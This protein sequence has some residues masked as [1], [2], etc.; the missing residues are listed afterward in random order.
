[1]AAAVVRALHHLGVSRVAVGAAYTGQVTDTDAVLLSR[2]G[3][4]T[5]TVIP[6]LEDR[7]GLPVVS[8]SQAG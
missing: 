5:L 3:L 8:S 2:G 6:D 4:D 7:W 1:M